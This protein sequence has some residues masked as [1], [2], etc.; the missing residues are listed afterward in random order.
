MLVNTH[1]IDRKGQKI[2]ISAL[3]GG[4]QTIPYVGHHCT[5]KSIPDYAFNCIYKPT[6]K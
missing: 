1:R 5:K 3:T 6:F 4:E 2:Y